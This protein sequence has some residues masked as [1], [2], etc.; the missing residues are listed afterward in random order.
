MPNVELVVDVVADSGSIGRND[1]DDWNVVAVGGRDNTWTV[2]RCRIG[3]N[4]D[5]CQG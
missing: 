3:V 4:D 2:G 5:L 1:V